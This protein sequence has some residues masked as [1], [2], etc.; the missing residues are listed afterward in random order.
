MRLLTF[1]DDLGAERLGA[2]LEED[3]VVDLDRAHELLEGSSHPAL[4][5]MLALIDGQAPALDL[6]RGM[7][8]RA[9]TEA[10]QPLASTPLL[11]PLPR[12]RKLRDFLAFEGHLTNMASKMET[13]TPIPP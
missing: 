9:P 11:A 10:V 12:P 8:E 3:A 6:A 4:G 13:P 2:L 7:I 1:A 5:S